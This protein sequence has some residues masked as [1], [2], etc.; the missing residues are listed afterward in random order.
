MVE[1]NRKQTV[2]EET[3]CAVLFI[4]AYVRLSIETGGAKRSEG[5][6]FG[7]L[8][9]FLCVCWA[10]LSNQPTSFFS[11]QRWRRRWAVAGVMEYKQE[12]EA[13]KPFMK[14]QQARVTVRAVT[15]E[16]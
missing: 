6:L 2:S 11:I 15:V 7:F 1:K 8:H 3:S 9:Q 16:I 4:R 13:F 10:I 14:E 12:K 5:Y